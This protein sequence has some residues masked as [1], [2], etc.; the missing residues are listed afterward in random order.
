[1]KINYSILDPTGNITILVT[2]PV[3]IADQPYVASRLMKLEPGAEQA[4][5]L[6]YESG[7]DI[8]LRMA[9]GEFCGNASMCAA[10]MAAAGDEGRQSAKAFAGDEEER[11]VTM[12]VSGAEDPVTAKVRKLSDGTWRGAVDM[13]RPLAIEMVDLP[14][15][16]MLPVVSFNGISHV[17]YEVAKG[18]V[19]DVSKPEAE[20]YV[21]DWCRFLG[22]D[23]LGIM[24]LDE[25][26]G[27]MMPLVYVPAAGTL[28]WENSC[29][30]GTTACG[31]YLAARA[32][33]SSC[34]SLAQP[35]GSLVIE[36]GADGS[37]LLKGTVRLLGHRCADISDL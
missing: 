5:F 31:A 20:N 10:V 8:A 26:A 3:D 28:F 35:G 6:T 30:S 17:I 7:C 27:R 21:V 16:G 36:A 4:G 12:R 34:V 18:S 2:T 29:A 33:G 22:T 9:G 37:V 24:F 13:P 1:M 19:E 15:A 14:G 32:G 23:A 25:A 11:N